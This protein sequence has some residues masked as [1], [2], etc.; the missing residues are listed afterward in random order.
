M[1]TPLFNTI[2]TPALAGWRSLVHSAQETV[3]DVGDAKHLLIAAAV[4]CVIY[5]NL[6]LARWLSASIKFDPPHHEHK[7]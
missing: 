7:H 1:P 5:I 6:R 4:L 2:I 3:S